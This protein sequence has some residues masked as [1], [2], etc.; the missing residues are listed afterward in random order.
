MTRL[1]WMNEMVFWAGK[2]KIEL[3]SLAY[4]NIPSILQNPV[5]PVKI[6]Q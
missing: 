4:K 6:F 3:L 1:D 2:R 5:N